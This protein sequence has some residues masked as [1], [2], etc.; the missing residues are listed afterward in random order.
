[1]TAHLGIELLADE[2]RNLLRIRFNGRVSARALEAAITALAD[3]MKRIRPGFSVLTDLSPLESMELECVQSL[4]R[5][6]ELFKTNGVGTVVRV[7]PDPAK[8]IGFNILSITHYRGRVKVVTCDTIAE[9][10]RALPAVR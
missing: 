2:G 8:D 9:A 3:E 10:E 1:M 4:T 5:M 7:I 6:M